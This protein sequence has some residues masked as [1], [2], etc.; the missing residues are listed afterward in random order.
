MDGR[1]IEFGTEPIPKSL[2]RDKRVVAEV[3]HEPTHVDELRQTL[4]R[5]LAMPDRTSFDEL[6]RTAVSQFGLT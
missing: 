2:I 3:E 1:L 5:I 4:A 6:K